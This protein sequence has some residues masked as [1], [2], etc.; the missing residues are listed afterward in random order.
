MNAGR[1]WGLLEANHYVGH[2]GAY[3]FQRVRSGGSTTFYR[4]YTPVA[5]MAVG[6]FLAG[7]GQPRGMAD[8][9]S[10]AFA[11]GMSSNGATTE[12][13]TFRNLA[14]DIVEGKA[15]IVCQH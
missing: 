1:D 10:N 3:D 2:Y 6:F 15:K 9:I 14:Y 11:G 4:Q 8:A 5:N 12:Q 7:N 13:A